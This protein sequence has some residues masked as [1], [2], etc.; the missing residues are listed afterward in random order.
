MRGFVSKKRKTRRS[1]C[2][3]SLLSH[4]LLSLSLSLARAC[5]SA[6]PQTKYL[7]S[8]YVVCPKS[9]R[10]ECVQWGC[11]LR[12]L[13]E[14]WRLLSAR[15]VVRAHN[16]GR[17][18]HQTQHAE[19]QQH[20]NRRRGACGPTPNNNSNARSLKTTN[21]QKQQF[22]LCVCECVS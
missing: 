2:V 11:M 5:S 19:P 14:R 6:L 4:S 17:H 20:N 22:P 13:G 21:Q 7:R 15:A 16:R 12:L 8:V 3:L 1:C 10:V 18:R 9:G